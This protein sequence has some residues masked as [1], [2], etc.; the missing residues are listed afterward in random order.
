LQTS[1]HR[2]QFIGCFLCYRISSC[3]N[4]RTIKG[5]CY[6]IIGKWFVKRLGRTE[7]K[8]TLFGRKT[9]YYTNSM[10]AKNMVI[11][12]KSLQKSTPFSFR[13]M[14]PRRVL[15]FSLRP[16]TGC[17]SVLIIISIQIII[18]S[19]SRKFYPEIFKRSD[20][21]E[22]IPNQTHH[23][24]LFDILLHIINRTRCASRPKIIGI[25]I[26]ICHISYP[27]F[28]YRCSI[29]SLMYLGILTICLSGTILH[30]IRRSHIHTYCKIFVY[31]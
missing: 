12:C 13:I 18:I 4:F 17:T 24:I 2:Q 1:K 19:R 14:P 27:R 9:R 11:I 23:S 7:T 31:L 29:Q 28:R 22:S 30:N 6:G 21:Y 10:I 8:I 5:T 3:C 16:T 25:R 26:N 15:S 20:T